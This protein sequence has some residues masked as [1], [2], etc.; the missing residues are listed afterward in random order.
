M[1]DIED[2][3]EDAEG[4]QRLPRVKVVRKRARGKRVA[5]AEEMAAVGAGVPGTQ[6]ERA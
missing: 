5:A 3:A 6:V 4:V 1:D 2:L